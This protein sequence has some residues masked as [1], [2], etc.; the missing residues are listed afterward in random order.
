MDTCMIDL[1]IL[2]RVKGVDDA[3]ILKKKLLRKYFSCD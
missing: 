3:E 1:S 2:P